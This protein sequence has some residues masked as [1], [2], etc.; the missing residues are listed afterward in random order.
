M[1]RLCAEAQWCHGLMASAPPLQRLPVLWFACL[2]RICLDNPTD[3]LSGFFATLATGPGGVRSPDALIETDLLTFCERHQ[4]QLTKLLATS[5]TQ[6]NEVG[7]CALLLP[8]L[9]QIAR[10]T[11][12]P[13]RLFDVGSSA[14]LTLNIDRYNYRYEPGGEIRTDPLSPVLTCEIRGDLVVPDRVPDIAARRGLDLHP[15]DPSNPQDALWLQA[16][17]WADQ[18]DRGQTLVSAIGTAR[19][20]PVDVRTGDA[21][22]D[23]PQHLAEFAGDGHLTV[24]TTWV[25]SYLSGEQIEQFMRILDD[26]GRQ[27]DLTWLGAEQPDQ[28]EPIEVHTRHDV[29]HLTH[30]ITKEWRNGACQQTTWATAHPHGYWMHWLPHTGP[31]C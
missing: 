29:R 18:I 17:V 5:R 12:A 3:P 10:R 31:M 30:L 20:H 8:V 23:L 13:L 25:L 22:A 24:I 6:T 26:F 16:C 27:T 28:I 14:G 11:E 15:L 21:V 7:R 2:H 19:R 4:D 1:A 9:D